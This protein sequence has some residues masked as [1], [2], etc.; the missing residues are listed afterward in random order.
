MKIDKSTITSFVLLLL[1]ASLY[2]VVPNRPFGFAPQWAMAIFG[3]A[4]IKDKKL[5]FLLPLLSLFISDLIYQIL[6]KNGLTPIAGFYSGQ[7]INYILFALVTVIGFWVKKENVRSIFYGSFFG[8]T[9]FFIVSNF[10]VWI[11]G[12]DINNQPYPKSLSGLLYCYQQ[13]LPFYQN[14]V[15]ATLIFS[16]IL[17]GGYYLINKYVISKRAVVA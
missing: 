14:C 17:F 5:S 12:L 3:G 13:G 11:S 16:A 6:Y 15:F 8:A 7:V 10:F 4:V 1:I 9:F 2:R